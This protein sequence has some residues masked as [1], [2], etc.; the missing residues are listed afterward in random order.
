MILRATRFRSGVF[1]HQHWR[2]ARPGA[3]GT[4]A[5]LH[6]RFDNTRTTRDTDQLDMLVLNKAL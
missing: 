1:I 3:D 4:L 6:G 2:I 5:A